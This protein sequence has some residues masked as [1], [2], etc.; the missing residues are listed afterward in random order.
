[1]VG[2]LVCFHH[3]MSL[4]KLDLQAHMIYLE[5]VYI[6]RGCVTH[7]VRARSSTTGRAARAVHTGHVTLFS[8]HEC[9]QQICERPSS[10]SHLPSL[11]GHRKEQLTDRLVAVDDVLTLSQSQAS[12]CSKSTPVIRW[13]MEL[14]RNYIN[15]L[16]HIGSLS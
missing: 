3:I 15:F 8:T 10:A 12:A 11:P 13:Q 5:E 16:T 2:R 4:H 6:P 9:Q 1:M 7:A 14:H